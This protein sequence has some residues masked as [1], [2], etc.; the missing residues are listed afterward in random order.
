MFCG[1]SHNVGVFQW[2]PLAKGP[3]MMPQW[4]LSLLLDPEPHTSLQAHSAVKGSATLNR[5]WL[6]GALTYALQ[7]PSTGPC[8]VTGTQSRSPSMIM[9]ATA[10][11][12]VALVG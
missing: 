6:C 9:E 1:S 10:K 3:R 8:P 4:W 7:A 12:G 11:L 2:S 5:D